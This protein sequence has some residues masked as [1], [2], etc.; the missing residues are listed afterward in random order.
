MSASHLECAKVTPIAELRFVFEAL[1]WIFQ[2]G[3]IDR[4]RNGR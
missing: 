1:P 3:L 2:G 4:E